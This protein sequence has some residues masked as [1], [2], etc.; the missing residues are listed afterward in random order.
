MPSYFHIRYK[1]IKCPGYRN[2]IVTLIA[3]RK[4]RNYEMTNHWWLASLTTNTIQKLDF[5]TL[6][7][8]FGGLKRS[9]VR[10][11]VKERE[12]EREREREGERCL[13][14]NKPCFVE[15]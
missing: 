11:F 4:L 9:A 6:I 1:R 8:L 3:K 7:V 13:R 12:R 10:Y 15:V 14:Y 2:N 5:K